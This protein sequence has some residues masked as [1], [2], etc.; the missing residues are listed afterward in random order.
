MIYLPNLPNRVL[1]ASFHFCS[2][3]Y[4][5]SIYRSFV[6]LLLSKLEWILPLVTIFVCYYACCSI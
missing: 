5:G 4:R 2:A 6:S 3:M 1:R